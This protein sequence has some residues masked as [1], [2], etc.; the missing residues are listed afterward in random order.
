M[1]LCATAP[2]EFR[3]LRNDGR[4]PGPRTERV[5]GCGA[6]VPAS[7][8]NFDARNGRQVENAAP[9]HRRGADDPDVALLPGAFAEARARIAHVRRERTEEDEVGPLPRCLRDRAG[10]TACRALVDI[11]RRLATAERYLKPYRPHGWDQLD[12]IIVPLAAGLAGAHLSLY[13]KACCRPAMRIP[14][15][16]LRVARFWRNRLRP[17]SRLFRQLRR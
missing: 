6:I 5:R 16:P 9:L 8:S 11:E 12:G 7:P 2:G 17:R 15:P 1:S 10:S 4:L 13:G 14:A 3:L